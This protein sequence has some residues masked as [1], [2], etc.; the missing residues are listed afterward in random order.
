MLVKATSSPVARVYNGLARARDGSPSSAG[1]RP[2]AAMLSRGEKLGRYEIL[3]PLGAGGM[4]EVYRALDADLEREVAVKILPDELSSD[5]DRVRRF[6]REARAVAALAHPNVLTV[7]DVGRREGQVYIVFEKLEGSTLAQVMKPGPLR[8]R[9]ALEYGAQVARGLAAV[10][11]RGIVHRDLKP[12]NLFLTTAGIV[13]IIDFGLARTAAAPSLSGKTA[14]DVT[15]PGVALG[16]VSY[17]SPEQ[18]Q[19]LALDTRSDIFSFGTVLYEMLSG[20]H[21]WKRDSAAGTV[22]SIL[23]DDP[24]DL[25]PLEGGVPGAIAQ[26]VGRC[27]QKRPED[28]F[29]SAND[30]ALALDLLKRGERPSSPEAPAAVPEEAQA[31]GASG[32]L[33]ALGKH[34]GLLPL[35]AAAAV[36]CALAVAWWMLRRPPPPP[37]VEPFTTVT[38]FETSPT[39]SP[40]GEQVAFEWGGDKSDN[41]DIY[42]KPVGSPELRRLTTDPAPD[43]APSWSPDGRQIAFVRFTPPAGGRIHVVSPLTGVDR[44]ISDAPA[45]VGHAWTADGQWLAVGA[46]AAVVI[47]GAQGADRGIRLVRVSDGEVRTITSPPAPFFHVNPAFSPDGRQLAYESCVQAPM[48]FLELL[49]L[50]AEAQR[51]S[52]P[53]RLTRRPF[54]APG[55]GSIAWTRDGGS[56]LLVAGALGRLYRVGTAGAGEPELVELA[57]Y[58][59]RKVAVAASRDRIVIELGQSRHSIARFVA[60][61]AAET[62]VASTFGDSVPDYSPDGQR[63]VFES[64]RNGQSNEIWLAG[65]D[66]SNPIQLTHGPGQWQGSPR[67]SPDGRT[68]AFDSQGEDGS[69]DVWTIDSSGGPPRR[70]TSDPANDNLP[71]WSRD[72]RFIYW[73][74][75]RT[76]PRAIWRA[77]AAGG[78]EERVTQ[79]SGAAPLESADGHEL[80]FTPLGAEQGELVA[81]KL[82][83][84]GQRTA[85]ECVRGRGFVPVTGG[86]YHV[87]CGGPRAREAP[88]YLLDLATGRDRLL[89]QLEGYDMGLAVSPDGRAILY[90]RV[91]GEGSDLMLIENFR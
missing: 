19:G 77:P 70:F 15:G 30:L 8:M 31:R 60:G 47:L 44:R 33:R 38:G 66:G 76:S 87:G 25:G 20:R 55:G 90:T 73:S 39:F 32:S 89:G 86:L 6:E 28:R 71:S 10:H 83:D 68:I 46:P 58:N 82:A 78:A 63:I 3:A 24:P 43:W 21:P 88:L 16:T 37:R 29:Q 26:L 49:E 74:S 40:D 48:C 85:V 35:L 1:E 7:F 14:T 52:S 67:F 59:L 22:A 45:G 53:R 65:A 57:G 17:M 80:F 12:A 23:R 79:G 18:S 27:L 54:Y 34:R 41:T 9:E 51:R 91:Q 75:T 62:V 42:I 69:W 56:L 11:G 36:V 13:K 4:G 81:T 50:G 61:R 72:G 5:P 2:A 64:R 84:G